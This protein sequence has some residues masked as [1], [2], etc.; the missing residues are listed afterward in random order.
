[1]I[2]IKVLTE[3]EV[4]SNEKIVSRLKELVLSTTSF[5]NIDLKKQRPGNYILAY[6]KSEIIA[7]CLMS[8][9][10]DGSFQIGVYVSPSYRRKGIGT[11]LVDRVKKIA[12][13]NNISDFLDKDIVGSNHDDRSYHFFLANGIEFG[14]YHL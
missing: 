1:M 10:T 12:W 6:D 13:S 5:F 11:K 9:R 7:W 14:R 2:K 8:K 3:K 4:Y